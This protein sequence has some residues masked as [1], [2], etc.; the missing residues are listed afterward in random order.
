M[1]KRSVRISASI[2]VCLLAGACAQPRVS[3]ETSWQKLLAHFA[4]CS[5]VHGYDPRYLQDLPENRLGK[6][7]L[8]WRACAYQG[9]EEIMIPASSVPGMFRQLI[10]EDKTMTAKIGRG[11][12]KR[13]ERKARV[14]AVL[15]DIRRKERQPKREERKLENMREEFRDINR[16]RNRIARRAVRGYF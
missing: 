15:A 5:S 8:A 6:G 11:E 9:V 12:L 13:S 4:G 16:S 10:Q 7:E 1:T 14:T 2:L 3:Y